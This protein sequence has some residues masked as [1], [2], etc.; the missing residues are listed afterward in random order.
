M[1]WI[2]K[3]IECN[4][5]DLTYIVYTD[6]PIFPFNFSETIARNNKIHSYGRSFNGFAAWLLP[7]EAEQLSRM[8]IKKL[9]DYRKFLLIQI[10]RR[11]SWV[12]EYCNKLDN[13]YVTIIN[14]VL[15]FSEHEGVVSVFKNTVQKLHTTRSWDFLRFS[16]KVQRNPQTE[17]DII[18]ALMDTG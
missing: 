13:K 1:I 5:S 7:H 10:T 12:A 2:L 4:K 11:I 9:S 18:V 16:N 6:C 14:V 3:S 15:I 8:L 17:S